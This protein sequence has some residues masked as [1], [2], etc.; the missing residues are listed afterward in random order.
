MKDGILQHQRAAGEARADPSLIST[1]K[2]VR[3][4][5]YTHYVIETLPNGYRHDIIEISDDA[6]LRQIPSEF[7]VPP[8]DYFMMGDNRDNSARTAARS[9]TQRRR[10]RSGREHRPG[11]PNSFSSRPITMRIGG[12][13]GNG[14]LPSAIAVSSRAFIEMANRAH[15]PRTA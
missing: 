11:A 9:T 2:M 6:P 7:T 13:R 5:T 4:R 1:R 3:P 10:L 12:R 8:G 14:P 15:Q